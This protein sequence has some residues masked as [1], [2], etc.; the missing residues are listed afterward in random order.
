MSAP[1]ATYIGLRTWRYAPPTTNRSVGAT[2]A[3]VPSPSSTKRTNASSRTTRPAPIIRPPSTR[4]GVHH[5]SASQRVRS[6]GI[7]PATTPGAIMRKAKLWAAARRRFPGNA[8]LIESRPARSLVAQSARRGS[9]PAD[10]AHCHVVAFELV[11]QL[12][13]LAQ[14]LR[15]EPGGTRE[16]NAEPPRRRL[17]HRL[18]QHVGQARGVS[19]LVE[20]NRQRGLIYVAFHRDLEDPAFDAHSNEEG[21]IGTA[22]GFDRRADRHA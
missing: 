20:K 1:T 21:I 13:E 5:V 8:S 9:L 18:V 22:A 10:D 14:R 11:E 17:T 4:S 15:L 12:H 7:S 6:H 19:D 3:G 2:G 16:V